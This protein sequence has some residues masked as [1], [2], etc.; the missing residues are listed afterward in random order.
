[1]TGLRR[2]LPWPPRHERKAAINRAREQKQ[3]SRAAAGHAA[4]VAESI[5]RMQ[6]E[7]HF[8]YKIAEE[9]A[10]RHGQQ[11]TG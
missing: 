2:L 9:I 10:R 1:M 3:H 6:A 7:N 4:S 5:R 11:G 8:A